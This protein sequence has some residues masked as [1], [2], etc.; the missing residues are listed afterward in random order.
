MDVEVQVIDEPKVVDASCMVALAV[1]L[2]S[3]D[4]EYEADQIGIELA[5]R[6]GSDQR[7]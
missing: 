1:T 2:N 7:P 5:A 3:R 6:V 4:V